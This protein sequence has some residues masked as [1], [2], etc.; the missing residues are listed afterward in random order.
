MTVSVVRAL[1]ASGDR[2]A[3]TPFETASTP[4]IALHPSAKARISNSKP[5]VSAGTTSGVTPV[6]WG[7]T[8]SD[9]LDDADPDEREHRDDEHVRRDGEDRAA[10]A[11]AAQVDEHHGH[12]PDRGELDAQ[13]VELSGEGRRDRRDPRR[14]TYR[15]RQDVVGEERCRRDEAGPDTEVLPRH[16]VAAAAVGV[17]TDGLPIRDDDDREHGHDQRPRSA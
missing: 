9:G 13:I 5:S 11:N 10:L 4:V 1:R 14:D 3:G 16:D 15:D 6:T 2:N 17:G 12:D 8:P 7:A